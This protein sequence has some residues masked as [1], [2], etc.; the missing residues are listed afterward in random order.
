M[1]ELHVLFIVFDPRQSSGS[2]HHDAFLP[3]LHLP[4]QYPCDKT[5]PGPLLQGGLMH[6]TNF[7]KATQEAASGTASLNPSLQS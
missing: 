5:S 3:Q 2:C 1:G 4:L 6:R 7:L